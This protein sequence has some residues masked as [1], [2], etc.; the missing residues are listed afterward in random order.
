M[1]DTENYETKTQEENIDTEKGTDKIDNVS[2]AESLNTTTDSKQ[3]NNEEFNEMK[4][5]INSLKQEIDHLKKNNKPTESKNI[6]EQD[7]LNVIKREQDK[8]KLHSEIGLAMSEKRLTR[9]Q[10]QMY[11][12]E[13]SEE[14]KNETLADI[15]VLKYGEGNNKSSIEKIDVSHFN[16]TPVPTK[17]TNQNKSS[18]DNN[19]AWEQFKKDK[20]GY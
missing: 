8:E 20:N 16:K 19:S 13:I 7:V 18:F 3:N 4:N 5:L 10:A 1:N 14:K 15:L 2:K 9:E 17:T 6:N 11:I 12:K